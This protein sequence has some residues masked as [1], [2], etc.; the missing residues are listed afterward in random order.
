MR[1]LLILFGLAALMFAGQQAFRAMGPSQGGTFADK[2]LRITREAPAP[3]TELTRADGGTAT[4][5]DWRGDVAVVTMW[6]TWCGVCV[7]EMPQLQALA[8]RYEGR[9]L[10]V[11]TVSVDEAPAEETVLAH[12]KSRGLDR[13]PPLIDAEQEMAVKLGLRG[14]PTTFIV[15]QFGQVTAAF[16]G[17]APWEDEATHEYLE[18]LM[19]AT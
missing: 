15:D 6:A 16:E 11:L 10:S 7:R 3:Q 19:A 8:E 9:G 12:L 14:T 17:L 2:V 18:S 1:I 5:A 4:L 13:L